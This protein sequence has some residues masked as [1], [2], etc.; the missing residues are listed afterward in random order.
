M[1]PKKPSPKSRQST[2]P[3]KS[4][5]PTKKSQQ[6]SWLAGFSKVGRKQGILFVVVFALIGAT[7]LYIANADI[8]RTAANW[9]RYAPG[10]RY[11]ESNGSGSYSANTGNGYYGAYQFDHA[12][13]TSYDGYRIYHY[14]NANQAPKNIQDLSAYHM[15]LGRGLQPWACGP[16]ALSHPYGGAIASTGSASAAPAAK[17][18]SASPNPYTPYCGTG[19]EQTIGNGYVKTGNC[20]KKLQW[21]LNHI[22]AAGL[23]ID[24]SFGPLSYNAVRTFQSRHALVVDGVTGRNTWNKLDA[25]YR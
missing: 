12:T 21:D 18:V 3:T 22:Q 15:F 25:I 7:V 13:W 16:Y 4:V 10:L 24:G 20:V 6:R 23:A 11:C 1:A 2:K 17:P 19:A 5:K 14:Y 8:A 9:N